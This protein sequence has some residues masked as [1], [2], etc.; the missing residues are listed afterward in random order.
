MNYGDEQKYSQHKVDVLNLRENEWQTVD[1]LNIQNLN[2]RTDK[3]LFWERDMQTERRLREMGIHAD[4]IPPIVNFKKLLGNTEFPNYMKKLLHVLSEA[5]HYPVDV[6]FTVNFD[7]QGEF[8]VNLLQCRPQQTRGLGRSVPIPE[9]TEAGDCIFYSK[10]NFM[11][12]NVR[13]PIDYIV[14]VCLY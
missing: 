13:L 1:I 6:E 7:E 14:C 2:I 9:K 8:K 5:Y 11:G 12:G 3:A 4:R 10:G